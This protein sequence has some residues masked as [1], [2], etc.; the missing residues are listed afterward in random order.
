VAS[1]AHVRRRQAEQQTL[2][3]GAGGSSGAARAAPDTIAAI[4]T[5]PGRAGIGVVRISGPNAQAIARAVTGKELEPR[6][7]AYAAFR[8]AAGE[9]I[10][11]GIAMLF[12]APHSYTGEDVLELQGHGGDA[13]LQLVLQRCLA[14]GCRVAE[15][16]EFSKRAF[17]N[18][19]LDL[20]QAEAVAGLIEAGS[21][22]AARSAMRSLSG[23]FSAK[24]REMTG[25]MVNLRIFVEASLDFPEEDIEWVRAH[26][27]EAK[28]D[29]LLEQLEL[30]LAHAKQGQ[31][32]ASGLNV[33]LLGQPNVGK[34][35]LLN[36]L[37]GEDLAIVT[38]IPGTTRDS[39]KSRIQIRG[40]PLHLV[41]TAGL[42]A[43]EDEVERLGIERTWRAAGSADLAILVV[44]ATQGVGAGERAIVERL[45]PG[46]KR[47][48]VFNKVDL[49]DLPAGALAE[50][51]SGPRDLD[52]PT[53]T[54][55]RVRLSAKTGQ[56]IEALQ[57][58]VLTHAG[59]S[60]SAGEHALLARERH[61]EALM[62]AHTHVK[63]A[64]HQATSRTR[65]ELLA[66]ELRLA[67][68][69]LGAITGEFTADDLL[70]EIFSKFCIG[71]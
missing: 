34:S 1:D 71:K 4:A 49:T 38:P 51:E 22:Q 54:P 42:R 45:P 36:R 56:G 31:L 15:P 66:E 61:I 28:L 44:D 17:L 65:L 60:T 25:V 64:K 9:A 26:Q 35:S 2:S 55:K 67:Q 63:D 12:Q 21:A 37:A 19:K 6:R 69:A 10:D 5:A 43:S 7:A 18:D 40:V 20:A 27:V 59:W 33:V 53:D 52:A 39:L 50:E 30:V 48:E 62:R 57:D 46:L 58:A 29:A 47:I 3:E 16:G 23:E 14:L 11:Q 13:V 41:D 8:D 24:V 68:R 32:L 70:G